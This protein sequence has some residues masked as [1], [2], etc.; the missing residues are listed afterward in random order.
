MSESAGSSRDDIGS[1]GRQ[2]LDGNAAAGPLSEVFSIDLTAAKGRCD[3]CGAV[4][5]VAEAVVY[6]DAPGLVVRCRS[7]EGVLLRLVENAD[8]IWLDVRGLTYLEIERG[9]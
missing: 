7:C 4:G 9:A 2:R 1:A 5:H 3:H 8:R 6:G